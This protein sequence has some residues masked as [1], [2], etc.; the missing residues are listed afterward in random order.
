MEPSKHSSNLDYLIDLHCFRNF[1]K[2]TDIGNTCVLPPHPPWRADK[3]WN[4]NSALVVC[5]DLCGALI[6]G[7][8]V[9]PHFVAIMEIPPKN[10]CKPIPGYKELQHASDHNCIAVLW[11]DH[12]QRYK[13]VLQLTSYRRVSLKCLKNWVGSERLEYFQQYVLSSSA[14]YQFVCS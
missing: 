1:Q 14:S 8:W 11:I 4:S 13:T 3:G 9:L 2:L 12:T 6:M 7:R 5:I 10:I